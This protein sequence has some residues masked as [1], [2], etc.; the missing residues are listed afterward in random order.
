M[1]SQ[2]YSCAHEKVIED[3][4]EGTVVCTS[5]GLVLSS[6]FLHQL[7]NLSEQRTEADDVV[8]SDIQHLLD[9]IH[10]PL[11]HAYRIEAFHKKNCFNKSKQS[12]AF[13][14]YR[15]LND[16]GIPITMKEVSN[17]SHIKKE[18][19]NRVRCDDNLIQIDSSV[20]V[21]KYSKLLDL[22]YKT[23]TV[24][25]K[26]ISS[27]PISG[28][29]PNSVLASLIYQVCKRS[30]IK[31]SIKKVAEVTSVSCISIQRYNNFFKVKCS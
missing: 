15:T 24:I 1:D 26:E 6:L 22:S 8:L 19:L 31:I 17:I 11:C 30:K 12:I 4:R 7:V 23:T 28:H 9:R 14:V 25:K 29:N 21:E 10:V 20:L 5:C 2:P 13:S 3:Y 27:A 16:I 18:S